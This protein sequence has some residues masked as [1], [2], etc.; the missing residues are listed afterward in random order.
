MTDSEA[1][2]SF[3]PLTVSSTVSDHSTP[4]QAVVTEYAAERARLLLGCYRRADAADP[5]TYVAAITA[6]LAKYPDDV[7]CAVTH[8]AE[9]LPIRKDFLPT[10]REVY[11]ACEAIVSPRREER[12]RRKRIEQQIAER[13]A[14][15]PKPR[16]KSEETSTDADTPAAAP[17]IMVGSREALAIETLFAVARIKPYVRNGRMLYPY[18]LTPQLLGFANAPP[19]ADWIWIEDRQQIAAWNGFLAKHITSGRPPLVEKVGVRMGFF[20]P[21][22]FPLK[23]DGTPCRSAEEATSQND[24]SQERGTNEHDL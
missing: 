14:P 23:V 10:V 2:T 16:A 18:H 8:P 13:V 17:P 12:A 9:G 24:A 5:D 4:D 1:E 19:R 15:A 11:L 21:W 20:A 22:E 3:K 6:V 7:I